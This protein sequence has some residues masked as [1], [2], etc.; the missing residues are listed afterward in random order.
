MF[1]QL[2][3]GHGDVRCRVRIVNARNRDVVY[4]SAEQV[5]RFSDRLQTR[6]FT[7]RLVGI[8]VHDPGDFWVEFSCNDQ[9]VDDAVLRLLG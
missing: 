7:L 3:G 8:T 5:V 1:A 4:E 6:Y 2:I 9:F